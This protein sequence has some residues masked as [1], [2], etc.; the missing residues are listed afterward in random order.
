[1]KSGLKYF[2]IAFCV[3]LFSALGIL[4]A[5]Q[6]GWYPV[7]IVN[8]KI[9]WGR[10]LNTEVKTATYYLKQTVGAQPD[11]QEVKRGVLE[12]LIEKTLIS[13]QLHQEMD[14]AELTA[15]I[16]NL[17]SKHLEQPELGPAASYLY[18]LDLK[19]FYNIVLVPQA[20]KELL[21]KLLKERGV[22][23]GGWLNTAKES[24]SVIYITKE[25]LR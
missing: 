17:L 23:F 9:I 25:L 13:K 14:V 11:Y 19:D 21:E 4:Y 18:G 10:T 8:S 2:T 22:E 7:A 6:A 5:I 24:A 15:S 20:E 12:N 1:M 3:I 16:N